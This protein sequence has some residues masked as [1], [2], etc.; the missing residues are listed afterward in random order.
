M[1]SGSASFTNRP[2]YGGTVASKR[3][4]A[5]TGF[6][7]GSPSASLTSR[8]ISPKAGARC[9]IPDPSSTVTKSAATTRAASSGRAS[10]SKGR[11]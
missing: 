9:T 6:S 11:R 10:R 7:T 2:A 8:S 5:S 3:A 4:A 1:R